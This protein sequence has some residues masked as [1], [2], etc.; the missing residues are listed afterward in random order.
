MDLVKISHKLLLQI[1]QFLHFCKHWHHIERH[2]KFSMLRIILIQLLPFIRVVC[3][4]I[5]EFMKSSN[6]GAEIN[7]PTNEPKVL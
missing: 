5:A 1:L 2:F 3:T 7:P 4:S 6:A